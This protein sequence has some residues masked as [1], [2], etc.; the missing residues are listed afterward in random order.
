[1]HLSVEAAGDAMHRAMANLATVAVSEK[2][3]LRFRA[4]ASP[5]LALGQ[6]EEPREPQN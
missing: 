1:M 4:A 5:T 6:R 2:V 3:P